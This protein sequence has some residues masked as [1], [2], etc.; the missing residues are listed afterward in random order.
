MSMESVF[1]EINE[2]FPEFSLI[3]DQGQDRWTTIQRPSVSDVSGVSG[4]RDVRRG[5]GVGSLHVTLILAPHEPDLIN[6]HISS[7]LS[8]LD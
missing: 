2:S 8:H 5:Q 4:V 7:S 6:D 1:Q 3:T